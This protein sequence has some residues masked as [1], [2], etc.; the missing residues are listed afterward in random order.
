MTQDK[1]SQSTAQTSMHSSFFFLLR[2]KLPSSTKSPRQL[3]NI[4]YI[5]GVLSKPSSVT[6]QMITLVTWP[7]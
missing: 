7:F 6:A 1:G 3:T 4:I 2:F 5:T